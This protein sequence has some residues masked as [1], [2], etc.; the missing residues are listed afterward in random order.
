M[1][2][3]HMQLPE[4]PPSY[5][6]SH[7][8][9]SIYLPSVP[10]KDVPQGHHERSLPPSSLL[11][12]EPV[13]RPSEALDHSYQPSHWPS[14]NPLSAYYQPSTLQASPTSRSAGGV[15]SPSTM[16]VDGANS[17][18]RSRRAG[19]VLSMDDPDV[20]IAAEALGDLRAGKYF[21]SLLTNESVH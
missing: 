19:S 10:S 8:P 15:E 16:D 11:A 4:R 7:D 3:D 18:S 13:Q 1:E 12:V 2:Q 9:Q 21:T 5:S 6:Q 20:R 14:S 17:D